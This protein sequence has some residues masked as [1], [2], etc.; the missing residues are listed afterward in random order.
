MKKKSHFNPKHILLLLFTA[1]AV[2]FTSCLTDKEEENNQ[3]SM[4]Q[5]PQDGMLGPPPG[6]H[7][8]KQHIAALLKGLYTLDGGEDSRSGARN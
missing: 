3:P 6:V 7:A 8:D 1:S 4:Q 5:P 2:L